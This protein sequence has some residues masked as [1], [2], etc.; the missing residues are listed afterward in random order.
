MQAYFSAGRCLG[1]RVVQERIKTLIFGCRGSQRLFI[2]D[3]VKG[4][5][6]RK[7]LVSVSILQY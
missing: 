6:G 7:E 1:P 5:P 4:D 3:L 2:R